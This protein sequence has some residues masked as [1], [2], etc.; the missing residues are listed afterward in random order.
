MIN[1]CTDT[2][3]IEAVFSIEKLNN[4][5]LILIFLLVIWDRLN[6]LWDQFNYDDVTGAVVNTVVSSAEPKVATDDE[7]IEAE[8]LDLSAK[9][10]I[11]VVVVHILDVEEN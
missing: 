11:Y 3:N 9:S 6:Y 1:R 10:L 4:A 5:D 2:E 8:A 7:S